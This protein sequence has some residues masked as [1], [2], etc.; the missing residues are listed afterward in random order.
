MTTPAAERNLN[1]GL[2]QGPLTTAPKGAYTWVIEGDIRDCF[3]S[4]DHKVLLSILR[5][6]IR[7]R[8]LLTV[9][10]LMLK[11]G[12]LEDLRFYETESGTPQGGIVSPLLANIYM[13]E[14]D[15]FISGQYEA[16]ASRPQR[17]RLARRGVLIPCSIVRYADDFVVLVRGTEQQAQT[18]KQAIAT[19]LR[20]ALHMDLSVEKTLVTHITSGFDFLGYTIRAIRG[21]RDGRAK[22]IMRPSKRSVD[23]YRTNFRRICATLGQH[24]DLRSMF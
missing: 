9:V 13:H 6:T 22:V 10:R 17:A 1:G 18:L 5:R 8:A 4:I 14:L 3:G 23:R 12:A 15:Q 24:S 21:K 20:E 11:A 7:D 19:F 2:F 16:V